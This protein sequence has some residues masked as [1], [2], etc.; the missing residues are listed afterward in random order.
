MRKIDCWQPMTRGSL[1]KHCVCSLHKRFR[2]QSPPLPLASLGTT[3][4]FNTSNQFCSTT[5]NMSSQG[6]KVGAP[7]PYIQLRDYPAYKP[8]NTIQETTGTAIFSTFIGI[9]LAALR[10][11]LTPTNNFWGGIKANSRLIWL[12]RMYWRFLVTSWWAS[13]LVCWLIG[14]SSAQHCSIRFGAVDLVDES[15]HHELWKFHAWHFESS[16]FPRW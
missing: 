12:A 4:I 8:I 5:N 16:N 2:S 7:Y 15:I 14:I 1:P 10:G 11:A 13:G 3:K 9:S 6:T